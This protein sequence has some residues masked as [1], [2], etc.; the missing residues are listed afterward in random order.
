M[1]GSEN[2]KQIVDE[3]IFVAVVVVV[4]P[5]C[6]IQPQNA[7]VSLRITLTECENNLI[8]T[9]GSQCLAQEL[10]ISSILLPSNNEILSLF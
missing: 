1:R 9:N 10:V 4:K 6:V 3:H 2:L 8:K 5:M 7:I